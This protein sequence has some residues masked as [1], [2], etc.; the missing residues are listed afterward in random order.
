M[1]RSYIA[2]IS[3]KHTEHDAAIAKQVHTLIENYII[4]RSLRKDTKKLGIVFRDEEELP[5]SSDLTESICEALDAS[6]YLIVVCSPE[7]KQ[8][9]WVAREINYF[10]AHHR[11]EDAFVV[12]VGGEPGDVFPPQLTHILDPE[13]GAYQDVEP[14]ALD[15]RADTLSS[16]L[17]KP[18]RRSKSSWRA[19]WAAPMTAWCSGKKPAG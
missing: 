10:L 9:P 6:R 14:L 2:F 17:K 18:G 13:T 16:S 12:L 3:Y 4:P 5:I 15:V 11:P 19:C 7:A 8:S 1:E